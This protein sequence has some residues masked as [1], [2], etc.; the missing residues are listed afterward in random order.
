MPYYLF[1][2]VEKFLCADISEASHAPPTP[3]GGRAGARAAIILYP[4]IDA[5]RNFS[6]KDG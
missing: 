3:G 6:Q 5:G 1:T 2:I 4:A